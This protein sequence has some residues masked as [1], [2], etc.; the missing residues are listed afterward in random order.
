MPPA[1]DTE[2][3]TQR[4]A[5][6]RRL[7]RGVHLA[8]EAQPAARGLGPLAIVYVDLVRVGVRI[9]V[10]VRMRVRVRVGLR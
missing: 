6:R 9:R 8:A 10:R 3:C 2:A 7:R 1:P 5:A 4:G